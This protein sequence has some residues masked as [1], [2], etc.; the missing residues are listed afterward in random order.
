MNYYQ[1]WCN[2]K[3]SSKDIEFCESAKA[4]LDHLQEKKLIEGHLVIRRKLGFGPSE[5][6][7]FN[8]TIKFINLSQM[9]RAFE[10]VSTRT[11]EVERLH[12]KVYSAVKDVKFGL[13][14]DFPD[15]VRK[16]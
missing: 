13:Y 10:Y 12:K 1:I 11:G 14:R 15:P 8:I 4:Y 16:V 9:D 3:D 2:L 7:N 6:G 5:L